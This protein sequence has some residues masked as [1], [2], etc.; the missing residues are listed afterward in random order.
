MFPR[1]RILHCVCPISN[2]TN[3]KLKRSIWALFRFNPLS[4]NSDEN[5][6]SLCIVSTY[7][8]I[9]VMRLKKVIAKD[10]MS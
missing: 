3:L 1:H 7:S 8:N 9:Q 2:M 10:K 6:T 4:P 5:K